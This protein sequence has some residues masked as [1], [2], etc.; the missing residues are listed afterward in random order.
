MDCGVLRAAA[1][2]CDVSVFQEHEQ[3]EDLRQELELLQA[4]FPTEEELQIAWV[5][6]ADVDGRASGTVIVTVQL[7]PQTAEDEQQQFVRCELVL[8]VELLQC[9]S[10]GCP[11][12][13][14]G[15]YPHK[16]AHLTVEKSRGL[17]EAQRREIKTVL[18]YE[19]G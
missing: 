17:G 16:A 10:G 4:V 9:A 2:S 11:E 1:A 6:G 8:V 15:S 14:R 3:F 13:E 7:A 19:A 12:D 5:R 18:E